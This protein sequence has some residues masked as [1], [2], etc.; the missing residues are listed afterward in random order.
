MPQLCRMLK[1]SDPPNFL[2]LHVSGNNIGYTRIGF[3]RIHVKELILWIKAEMPDTVI[4]WS[5]VLPRSS[6][7]MSDNA[8]AM[9][10]ARYRLN[11]FIS[12]L[13]LGMG[14]RY[15]HYPDLRYDMARFLKPD[16]VHL[17]DIATHIMLN[18]LQGGIE[19]FMI[20]DWIT[21]FPSC[22]TVLH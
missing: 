5:Q 4:V 14:G 18:T 9:E 16:G 12:S 22:K 3:L 15:I 2:I 17:T 19:Q 1:F 8:K 21:T 7:R 11:N 13:V 6:W 10:K 20:N